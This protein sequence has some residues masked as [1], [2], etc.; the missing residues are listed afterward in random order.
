M[1]K[2]LN[3]FVA[4]LILS[5]TALAQDRGPIKFKNLPQEGIGI[6][7]NIANRVFKP[8][9]NGPFPAVVL[10]HTCGGV[11]NS[12][13]RSHAEF[14][15]EKNYVVFVQ[16][17]FGP[18]GVDYCRPGNTVIQTEG[19]ID[20]YDILEHLMSL[21]FVDKNRV[22]QAGFSWGGFVAQ[23]LSSKSRAADLN[24]KHRFRATV[25]FYATCFAPIVH[26]VPYDAD[27]PVLMLIAANDKDLHHTGCIE[28]LTERKAN[29]SPFE[30]FVY[31]ASHG[32][33]KHGQSHIGYY[34]DNKITKD[35][36]AKMLDF[37]EKY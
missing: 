32:W 29:G 12:H 27:R 4:I 8:K 3:T 28:H 20:A 21:A 1:K 22:F 5:S 34:F 15:L 9:G 24:S 36:L 11:G 19:V 35:S 16:D 10:T 23:L 18:R 33:D 31:E 25:S 17:S 7:T 2:L 37:F 30:W 6:F 14:L 13:I 26:A